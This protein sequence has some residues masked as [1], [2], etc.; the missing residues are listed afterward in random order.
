MTQNSLRAVSTLRASPPKRLGAQYSASRIGS[1]HRVLIKPLISSKPKK[2]PNRSFLDFGGEGGI[3][4]NSLRAVLTLRASPP[5][6]LG[7]QCSAGRIGS[8]HRVLIKPPTPSRSKKDPNR[9]FL[10][11]GGEGGIRTLDTRLTY[12]PLAGERLQP[13]G[14]F[15]VLLR[16]HLSMQATK[17]S[18]G[19]RY[20]TH[21]V[22]PFGSSS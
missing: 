9:S 6:R 7:A 21:C 16:S 20:S 12:T 4:Q 5:K 1:N 14:H 22:S 8:N 18:R 3:T 11:F 2:D 19:A 13:L 17:R 10:N 15:S